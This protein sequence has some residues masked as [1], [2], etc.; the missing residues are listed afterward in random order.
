MGGSKLLLL[1][2]V[3]MKA[4]ALEKPTYQ[5][6]KKGGLH[7]L[8]AQRISLGQAALGISADC[9]CVVALIFNAIAA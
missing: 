7:S 5:H 3:A 2:A 6:V 4:A 8:F 9:G 1:S